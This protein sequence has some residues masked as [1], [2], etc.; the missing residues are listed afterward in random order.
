MQKLEF[1]EFEELIGRI[2]ISLREKGFDGLKLV[3]MGKVQASS[4]N[5]E[6]MNSFHKLL[7]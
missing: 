7:T 1:S 6:N 4:P 5:S 2:G 3:R